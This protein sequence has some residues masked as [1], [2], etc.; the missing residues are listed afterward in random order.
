MI[1]ILT[2]LFSVGCA[3]GITV[4]VIGIGTV[5]HFGC[6][7]QAIA[8]AIIVDVVRCAVPIQIRRHAG[9]VIRVCARRGFGTVTVSIA[10]TIAIEAVRNAIAILISRCVT[11]I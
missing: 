9:A 7:V 6:V 4:W 2:I 5:K 11:A 8:V 10:I 3:V 1:R